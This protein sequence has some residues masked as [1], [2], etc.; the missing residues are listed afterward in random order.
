MFSPFDRS[1][2]S[3]HILSNTNSSNTSSDAAGSPNT[4]E[5]LTEA[6]TL[7]M[8]LVPA[9][10]DVLVRRQY[11]YPKGNEWIVDEQSRRVCWVPADRRS[12]SDVLGRKVVLGSTSGNVVIVDLPDTVS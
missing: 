8:V 6:I 5:V 10:D 7:P 12:C 9:S 2:V 1:V 11:H 4:T 3:V